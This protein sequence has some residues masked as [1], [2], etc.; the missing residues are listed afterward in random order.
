[1]FSLA[2][3]L[4]THYVL[5]RIQLN[6]QWKNRGT[7]VVFD[8]SHLAVDCELGATEIRHRQCCLL[9][10]PLFP[11]QGEAMRAPR[12]QH[13]TRAST[14]HLARSSTSR[15]PSWHNSIFCRGTSRPH[16]TQAIL[17]APSR[18]AAIRFRG[19]LV[20]TP[21]QS[22]DAVSLAPAPR[23]PIVLARG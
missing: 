7:L 17:N 3:L 8:E 5:L 11:L 20:C 13:R 12:T 21:P 19:R 23:R 14:L 9:R 6:Q 18:S 4:I 16:D 22:E 10:L 1:M 15:R 2:P